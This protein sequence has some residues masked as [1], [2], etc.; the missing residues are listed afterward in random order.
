MKNEVKDLAISY[1]DAGYPILYIEHFDFHVIDEMIRYIASKAYDSDKRKIIEFHEGIGIVDFFSKS[2]IRECSLSDFWGYV[3]DDGYDSSVFIVLKDIHDQMDKAETIAFLKYI[4]ERSLYIDDYNATIMIVSSKLK[5]P[6]ELEN[7]ITVI[8]IPLPDSNDI[9]E[10]IRE[11]SKS[12]Y[13]DVSE[14]VVEELEVSLKGLN[15]FQ[16]NQVLNLSYLNGGCL[17]KGDQKFILQQK[18]QLIKKSG[19]LEAIPAKESVENIG[20]LEYLVEW[21]EKKADVFKKIDKAIK[22]RVDIPKGVMIVG[23]PGCGKSLTAKVAANI[24]NTQLV[25]LDVGRLLGKYVGESEE[26]MR[27]ALKLAE[28]ISP[29][30]LWIDEIEKAFSGVGGTGGGSEVTTRLFGQFLTWMQEKENTVFIVATANDISNIPP[31]FL[32]KGRFDEVFFVDLPNKKEREEIIEI[33]LRKRGK[34]IISEELVKLANATEKYCGA[35]LEAIVKA[36]VEK[37][38]IQEKNT[39]TLAD[40]EEAKKSIKPI[41]DILKDKIEII[42]KSKEK[43]AL[44][45]ASENSGK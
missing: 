38:F 10:Q 6:K 27:L 41:S 14:E 39:I 31:E 29:C 34:K 2:I 42:E 1:V 44:Q 23:M 13:I 37:C 40:L 7:L 33:Q 4:A 17:E 32:R 16:I 11:F 19:L 36:A 3:K 22:Y 12:C 24:F 45:P 43:Y 30:V 25:R 35:D 20:G 21:L 15:E 9:K 18:G 26:N 8:D 28:A 5:I